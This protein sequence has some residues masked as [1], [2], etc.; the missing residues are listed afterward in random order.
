MLTVSPDQQF[1]HLATI[2]VMSSR[3][4][5][6][7]KRRTR[8]KWRDQISWRQ[9]TMRVQRLDEPSFPE[10]VVWASKASVIPSV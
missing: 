3:C 9:L 7:L 10:L 1:L 6:G 2:R 8:R 4:S 5:C